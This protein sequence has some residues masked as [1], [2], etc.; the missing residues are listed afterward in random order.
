LVY[1]S[2]VPIDEG[3][4]KRGRDPL[5]DHGTKHTI[6]VRPTTFMGRLPRLLG[7]EACARLQREAETGIFVNARER[8][9]YVHASAEGL[10]SPAIVISKQ[11]ARE[12]LLLSLETADDIL[13]GYTN[14]SFEI[15]NK[16]E[17][18]IS[19]VAECVS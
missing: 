9:L 4:Q 19:K 3:N 8:A 11:R 18:M 15:G 10:T 14:R 2:R 12:V 5:K 6:G 13:V 1:R 17:A 7:D 16:L